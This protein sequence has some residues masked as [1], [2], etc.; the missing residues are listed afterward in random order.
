[1]RSK[2]RKIAI[3]IVFSY[4]DSDRMIPGSIFDLFIVTDHCK[5]S[6]FDEIRILTDFTDSML[7]KDEFLI[8]KSMF[9]AIIKRVDKSIIHENTN[10]VRELFK[11][12][13]KGERRFIYYSGHCKNNHLEFPSYGKMGINKFKVIASRSASSAF[14]LIDCCECEGADLLYQINIDSVLSERLLERLLGPKQ[15]S[16]SKIHDIPFDFRT[17]TIP[18][19]DITK[20]NIISISSGNS[21]NSSFSTGQGSVFTRM[22]ITVLK[23]Y[24]DERSQLKIRRRSLSEFIVDV[25]KRIR[26]YHAQECTPSPTI[27]ISRCTIYHIP[28]WI[29]TSRDQIDISCD[30]IR[31]IVRVKF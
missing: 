23:T 9:S 11:G 1:M 2:V 27:Q 6:E 12:L 21:Q 19:T 26:D 15:Y 4:H 20:C 10:S 16:R 30:P 29:F 28:N 14:F 13:G 8:S 24:R 25:Y 7:N 17:R 22:I 3:I 18:D 5:S 31:Q